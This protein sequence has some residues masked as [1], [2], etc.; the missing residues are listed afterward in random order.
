[1]FVKICGVTDAEDALLAAGLGA[2][3][4]GMIFAASKRR[5]SNGAAIEIVRRLPP[6]VL[7]IGVFRDESKERVVE[8]ANRVGLR[9]VQL[10]GSESV[11]D[12]QWI[13]D[14]VPNVIRALSV[15][16]LGRYPLKDFRPARLL[17]DSPAPGSGSTFDWSKLD[18]VADNHHFILAGGLNPNNVRAAI[19]RVRPWGV[20]V[21]SGV[22]RAPGQKDP[23]KVMKFI[24]AARSA[25]VEPVEVNNS[26]RDG[27]GG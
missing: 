21:A 14:R 13:S 10:H 19:E 25:E 4:V 17:V 11:E 1:M 16:D 15:D 3:A 5:V 27:L 6:E 8:I 24:S 18:K 12:T 7:A 22:E 26:I 23:T 2:S 20:D 9:A